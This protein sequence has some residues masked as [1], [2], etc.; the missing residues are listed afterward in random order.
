[1]S[2]TVDELYEWLDGLDND[3]EIVIEGDFLETLGS[4]GAEFLEV[5]HSEE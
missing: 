1:M 5:G 3:D 4:N 2:V